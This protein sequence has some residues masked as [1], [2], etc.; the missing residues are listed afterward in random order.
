MHDVLIV[1]LEESGVYPSAKKAHRERWLKEHLLLKAETKDREVEAGAA[2]PLG[3]FVEAAENYGVKGLRCEMTEDGSAMMSQVRGEG[4]KAL[5][6]DY[7]LF[8]GL[9]P[10]GVGDH[11]NT[12][13]EEG[14]EYQGIDLKNGVVSKDHPIAVLMK[15]LQDQREGIEANI[16]GGHSEWKKG[17]ETELGVDTRLQLD[18]EGNLRGNIPVGEEF[19]VMIEG[20]Q[21]KWMDAAEG[22]TQRLILERPPEDT[23]SAG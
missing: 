20:A 7:T 8:I 10:D 23:V 21:F 18:E 6:A 19:K 4:W 1:K 22:E 12:L 15:G 9:T 2:E 17:D 3:R 5:G 14:R 13:L 16:I 11:H